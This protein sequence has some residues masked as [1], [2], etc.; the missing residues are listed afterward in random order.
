VPISTV[1]RT[2]FALRTRLADVD[3]LAEDTVEIG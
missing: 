3:R 1:L 2:R